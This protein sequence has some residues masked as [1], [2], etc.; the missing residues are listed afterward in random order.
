MARKFEAAIMT[1]VFLTIASCFSVPIIMYATDSHD[2]GSDAAIIR[3]KEL[4]DVNECPQQ[5]CHA[6]K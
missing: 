3:L 2:D 5:V 6:Y 4:I 1:A